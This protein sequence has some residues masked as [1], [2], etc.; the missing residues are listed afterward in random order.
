MSRIVVHKF[1]CIEHSEYD[2]PSQGIILLDGR[3]GIGKTSL[4]EAL[5]Y[6]F[7]ATKRGNYQNKYFPNDNS[8]VSYTFG[9]TNIY[10]SRNPTSLVVTH[11][12]SV[13]RDDTAQ[14]WINTTYGTDD[15]MLSSTYIRQSEGWRFISLTSSEKTRLLQ[16]VAKLDSVSINNMVTK[17]NNYISQ[18]NTKLS[19]LTTTNSVLQQQCNRLNINEVL[20]IV[21]VPC[22]TTYMTNVAAR[23]NT[24][25]TLI[26]SINNQQNTND[27]YNSVLSNLELRQYDSAKHTKLKML[28]VTAKSSNQYTV[29]KQLLDKLISS[30]DEIVVPTYTYI[31]PLNYLIS[32]Q[33]YNN[34]Q[35]LL[36]LCALSTDYYKYIEYT[37]TVELNK[38]IQDKMESLNNELV[39]YSAV[40]APQITMNELQHLL[41]QH[42]IF[43]QSYECPSC[44]NTLYINKNKLE[45][46]QVPSVDIDNVNLQINNHKLYNEAQKHINTIQQQINI[47]TSKLITVTPVTPV[48]CNNPIPSNDIQKVIIESERVIE[49]YNYQIK[50]YGI[51]TAN[52]I[53]QLLTT[54]AEYRRLEVKRDTLNTEINGLNATLNKLVYGVCNVDI[55]LLENQINQLNEDLNYNTVTQAKLDHALSMIKPVDSVLQYTHELNNLIIEE[56]QTISQYD[57]N[58]RCIEYTTIT[59]QITDNEVLIDKY[60]TMMQHFIKIKQA[61]IA[62]EHKLIDGIVEYINVTSNTILGKIF[63]DSINFMMRTVKDTKDSSKYEINVEILL[64][65]IQYNSVNYLSGGQKSRLYIT[66]C[67]LFNTFRDYPYIAFDESLSSLD[68]NTKN[69]IIDCIKEYLP[70]KLVIMVN[71]DTAI[72]MYDQVID[73]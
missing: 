29:N 15:I 19:E 17:C 10:R 13:Y 67:M 25:Q 52:N 4:L 36:Q 8:Y 2:L 40:V 6:V 73:L 44:N 23:K 20:N 70:N 48:V 26:N 66:L 45:L 56:Q 64:N 42:S 50:Y 33:S 16:E 53:T 39:K 61:I 35:R 14:Q 37:K 24:L 5:Y 46:I 62:G 49:Q 31:Q 55:Q 7:H 72:G 3:S 30:R 21:T 57:Y 65:D 34:A 68:L 41:C 58:K 38:L 71:H 32:D 18:Y 28:L 51:D 1:M 54:Q 47:I 60:T 11:N 59:Q 27:H 9:N 63:V 43:K 12:G 22:I 69:D